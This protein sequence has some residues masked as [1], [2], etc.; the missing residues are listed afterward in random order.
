MFY[1]TVYYCRVLYILIYIYTTG[2]VA[3]TL[4]GQNDCIKTNYFSHGRNWTQTVQCILANHN[5][6]PLPLPYTI[7][8]CSNFE[9]NQWMSLIIIFLR[10]NWNQNHNP[11]DSF[12]NK[13]FSFENVNIMVSE[14]LSVVVLLNIS[15]QSLC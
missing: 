12:L 11:S 5:T 3:I 14:Q 2:W 13:M 8:N 4:Q 15:A 6:T 9:V 1:T 7:L 10:F